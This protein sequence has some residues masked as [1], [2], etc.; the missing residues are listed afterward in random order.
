[1]ILLVCLLVPAVLEAGAWVLSSA[2]W[3]DQDEKVYENFVQALGE[4]GHGN[5]NKFIRDA[6]LNPLYGE[7][8]KKFSLSPDCA[9]LPYQLRAYVAYKLR[10]PFG[11]VSAIS[12]KG[13]DQRYSY[14]NKPSDFK[15]QDSFSSPQSLFG[16]VTLVNSGYY[17]MAPEVNNGDSYPIKIQKESVVPGTIYYDP[18]GHVAV[19][20]HVTNDGRIRVIDAHP[21]K[22]LSRPWFGGKFAIGGKAQGGGFRRWRPIWYSSDGHIRR[23]DNVNI[24]DFSATDQ[25]QKTF[26]LTGIG[27]VNYYDYVRFRLAVSG[28][29]INPLDEVR[30][31]ILEIFEDIKYRVEAVEIC[32]RANLHKREH[33]GALPYNIY[34]TDGEWEQYST[35][36]RDARLKVAFGELFQRVV[37]MIRMA[38]SND[39]NLVYSG[40]SRQLA[41]DL[42]RLYESL[43]PSLP[44]TYV[45]SLGKPVV[46]TFHDVLQRLFLLSFDPY[47]SPELRWGATGSELASANDSA[48]KKKMYSL[49]ARL[50]NHLERLYN[51]RTGFDLGPETPP[52]V[53]F[54]NWLVRYL[55]GAV[56]PGATPH[57][58][59]EQARPL[60]VMTT[61]PSTP[62]QVVTAAPTT[63]APADQRLEL[64]R[65]P[66]QELEQCSRELIRRFDLFAKSVVTLSKTTMVQTPS[67]K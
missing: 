4:S 11:Y 1:M 51:C 36:S 64:Q 10:L 30:Q 3:T 24:P 27:P 45:N 54:R 2:R 22:S 12:S 5:L 23:L 59:Q 58:V 62:A 34:G 48:L 56:S 52:D 43:N 61:L 55:N 28:G 29:K 17:R 26:Q 16:N 20:Y 63:V 35:P 9:D 44:V 67:Q 49:E 50:R 40:S 60:P 13:G 37:Q 33:P 7:E 42:L 57:I 47:H 65:N 32:L 8:D 39:P 18:N 15:D 46:L 66:E 38:E 25:Y 14:G 21:D 31:T 41:E 6:R 19:V 53:D